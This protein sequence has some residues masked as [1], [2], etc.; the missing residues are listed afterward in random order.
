MQLNGS[1]ALVTGATGG[2]GRAIA[3]E[4]AGRGAAL[5]VTGRREPELHKLVGELGPRARTLTA[6][7]A[8]LDAAAELMDCA[9]EVDILVANAGVGIPQDLTMLSDIEIEEAV[10]VNLLA[11]TA[12]ARAAAISMKRRGRGHIVFIS[13]G[14]G[15]IA[16]P[17][18]GAVYTATK[19]GLRGLGLALRQELHGTGVGISTIFPGPVRDAGML[20]DTGV[21]LPRGFGTSSPEDVAR[22]VAG[23]IEH[24]TAETTVASAGVRLLVGIGSVAPVLIGDLAR[25]A[26]VGRVRDAMLGRL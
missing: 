23:A 22:A 15:L 12:L 3:R 1:S 19:W 13:S 6:D 4:L 26:G 24:G 14:A 17:G 21:T 5:T 10:R 20:A 11:P 2:I 25:L 16:T 7:L 8:H 18:N 9:G